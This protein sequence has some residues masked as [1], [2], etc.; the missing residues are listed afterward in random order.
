M[1]VQPPRPDLCRGPRDEKVLKVLARR[2]IGRTKLLPLS[3]FIQE[4]VG[5]TTELKI[6]DLGAALRTLCDLGDIS[7]FTHRTE[8][9]RLRTVK[10]LMA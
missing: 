5:N 8:H 9:V 2:T 4:E 3:A 1:G 6:G 7:Y 10:R